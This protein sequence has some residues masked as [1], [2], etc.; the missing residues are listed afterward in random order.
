MRYIFGKG[1]I[2]FAYLL[3]PQK[4]VT[5]ALAIIAMHQYTAL[6][7]SEVAGLDGLPDLAYGHEL[8]EGGMLS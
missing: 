1:D 3:F 6:G 2:N 5:A 8:T 4:L 7:K